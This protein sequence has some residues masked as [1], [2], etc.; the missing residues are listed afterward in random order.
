[1]GLIILLKKTKYGTDESNTE[2][3]IAV[4]L[5]PL[6]YTVMGKQEAQSA[7]G[8][9]GSLGRGDDA[10]S[11]NIVVRPRSYDAGRTLACANRKNANYSRFKQ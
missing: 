4:M 1:M 9:R 11:V 3:G 10:S 7:A 5:I 8:I 6:V 2:R